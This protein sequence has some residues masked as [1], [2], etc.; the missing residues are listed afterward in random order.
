MNTSWKWR[1]DRGPSLVPYKRMLTAVKAFT[2]EGFDT[3]AA[4]ALRHIISRVFPH[5]RRPVHAVWDTRR[6]EMPDPRYEARHFKPWDVANPSSR[7]LRFDKDSNFVSQGTKLK[8]KVDPY[9]PSMTASINPL[10]EPPCMD[11]LYGPPLWT[12]LWPPCEPEPPLDP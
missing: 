9:G 5:A 4:D 12:P 3:P 11:P 6:E 1:I 8:A 7:D 10:S 2:S